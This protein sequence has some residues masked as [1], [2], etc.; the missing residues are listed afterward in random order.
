VEHPQTNGQAEAANKI[1]LNELKKK[2]NP[3]KGK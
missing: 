3:A 2:L 1:I